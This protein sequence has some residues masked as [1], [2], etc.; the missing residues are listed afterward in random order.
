MDTREKIIT[1]TP[2]TTIGRQNLKNPYYA[3]NI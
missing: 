1:M 3:R 2:K